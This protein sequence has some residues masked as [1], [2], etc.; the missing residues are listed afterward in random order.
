[1]KKLLVS[2]LGAAVMTLTLA[3]SHAQGPAKGPTELANAVPAALCGPGYTPTNI[4]YSGGRV[5]SY[6][7]SK[8][9]PD[10][11]PCNQYMNKYDNAPVAVGNSLKLSY[12]CA[13]PEG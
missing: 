11:R 9:I 10:Q 5:K 2:T 7:C 13:L 8:T 3:A 6:K 12:T 4:S 1:M